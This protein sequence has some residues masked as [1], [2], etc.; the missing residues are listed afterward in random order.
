MNASL[1]SRVRLFLAA[2]VLST[3]GAFG[4]DSGAVNG[5]SQANEPSFRRHVIPLLSR[6]GCSGRE[7]H[8]SFA[9][10]GGFRLSL[11]G[12]DFE[13]DHKALTEDAGGDE[14]EVRVNLHEPAKSLILL[15]PTEQVKHKGRERFKKDSW[16]YNLLARWIAA[17]AKDDAAQ[18]PEF[19]RL[20]VFPK[21]MVFSRP[22]EKAQVKV[23]G[24]RC[25]SPGRCC[26]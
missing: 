11:F 12:Y 5:A 15:K 16:E 1:L 8:G 26:K 6:A 14:G 18:A 7:C 22:D 24:A 10:R 4:L 19:D 23:P 25:R 2:L 17:G 9:G 20:E 21:E 3:G 13:A